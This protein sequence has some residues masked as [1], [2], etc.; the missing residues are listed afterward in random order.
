MFKT[1]IHPLQ[2]CDGIEGLRGSIDFTATELR[3]GSLRS[4]REVEVSLL[5]NGKVSTHPIMSSRYMLTNHSHP[6]CPHR[7]IRDIL[8]PLLLSVIAL[9]TKQAPIGAIDVMPYI[10]TR[11]WLQLWRWILDSDSNRSYLAINA[12]PMS[13][14]NLIPT[15][16]LLRTSERHLPPKLRRRSTRHHPQLYPLHSP[17]DPR[18]QLNPVQLHRLSRPSRPRLLPLQAPKSHAA[19]CARRSSPAL[20][21][22]VAPTYVV[23]CVGRV[24]MAM[25]WGFCVHGRVAVL[26]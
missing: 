20:L 1:V 10:W 12:I 5:S 18:P 3:T 8:M 11:S 21:A 2:S 7:S 25:Q 23:T 26:F 13:T 9:C 6:A 4:V 15:S 19:L 24:I 17:V 22:T 14:P 16:Q